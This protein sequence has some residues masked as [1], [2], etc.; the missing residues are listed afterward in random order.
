MLKFFIRSWLL[1]KKLVFVPPKPSIFSD[2]GATVWLQMQKTEV[3]R[4]D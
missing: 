2:I 3:V 1:R 4:D